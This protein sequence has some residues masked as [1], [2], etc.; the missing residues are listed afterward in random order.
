M[1][2]DKMTGAL[3]AL[4][5]AA[6]EPVSVA[7]LAGLLQMEKPQVWELISELKQSYEAES[8]GLMLRE[9]AGYFQLVTK[10]VYY[11]ILLGLGRKKE[12]KLTNASLETLA[13]VAF[14][15]PVTR[16]EMEAIRGVKV[17]GVLNTLL[18]LGLVA[19]AGRKKALGNPILYATTEKFLMVFGLNSLEELPPL[20]ARPEDEAEAAQ[21][22]LQLDNTIEAKEN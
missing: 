5:F 12:V 15:Q 21:Q 13:I 10:P 11:S 2:L 6:G 16:A 14:K 8:R 18:D 20:E 22:V 19:E 9:T 7:E 3:E 1:Y 4:L 17:D